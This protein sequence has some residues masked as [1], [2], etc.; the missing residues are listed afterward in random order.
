[1]GE[2]ERERGKYFF[3]L[4]LLGGVGER[5]QKV[6]HKKTE[7]STILESYPQF[8]HFLTKVIHNL[9]T[10]ESELSTI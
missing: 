9:S 8:R 10:I 7:L 2:K 1:M 3:S 6:I 4:L 5:G